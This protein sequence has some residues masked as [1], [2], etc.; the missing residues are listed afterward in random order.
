MAILADNQAGQRVALV[1]STGSGKSTFALSLFRGHTQTG[2]TIEID[3]IGKLYISGQR[4]RAD[5]IDIS[6]VALSE[7]RG[8]LNMVVQD[9]NLCSGTLR[10]TLD[11]TGQ[12]GEINM[13]VADMKMIK[14]YL[15]LFVESTFYLLPP[16]LVRNPKISIP[17]QISI[18]LLLSKGR[19]S[20]K[21]KDSYCVWL[22]LY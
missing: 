3:G 8:R 14:R 15:M 1:G 12:R 9:S 5:N 11:I 17:L 7:L 6:Q 22:G 20:V 16:M 21:A 13:G 10:D 19:I 4:H 18:P 2:G